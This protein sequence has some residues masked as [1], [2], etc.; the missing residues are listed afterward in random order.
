MNMKDMSQETERVEKMDGGFRAVS[1]VG[2]S[3]SRAASVE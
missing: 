3:A 1:G 2:F